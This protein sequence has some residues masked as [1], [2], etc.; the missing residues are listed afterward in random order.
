MNKIWI[1]TKVFIKNSGDTVTKGKKKTLPR[2]L[3]VLLVMGILMMSIGVP[4]GMFVAN[5]YEMLET[6]GQTGTILGFGI[7]IVSI[8]IFVFGI[9]YVLTT[10]YFSKD[11]EYLLPLPVKPYHI[12]TAKFVTVIIYEYFTEI[13]FL[14][15]VLV[16]YGIKS[17]GGF[18]YYFYSA[19][20]FLTLP[21][22]PLVVASAINMI[23]MRFTN[24][25]KHKDALRVAGGIFAMVFAIGINMTVQRNAASVDDPQ[26]MLSVIS[27]G[28]NS[29]VGL[30]SR[31]FP[32]ANFASWSLIESSSSK[33]IF[34]LVIFLGITAL[35]I[36]IFMIMAEMLYFRGV[37]GVSESYSKNRKLDSKT[38]EKNIVQSSAIKTYTLKELKLLFRTPSYFLNCVL[39]NFI[40]PVFLLLPAISQPEL[41]TALKNSRGFLN[42]T[43][44][45]GIVIAAGFGAGVFIA[46][47]TGISA[48]AISREGQNIF[49]GKYLPMRYSDQIMAKV[50]S[51]VI[52]NLV[53]IIVALGV[54]VAIVKL[55][56]YLIILV[57]IAAIS[58]IFLIGFTGIFIDLNFPKLNWDNEQKAV[59]QNFN[60]MI[61]MFLAMLLAAGIVFMTIYFKLTLIQAFVGIV[62]V[63]GVINII[64]FYILSTYG[65]KLYNK[66]EA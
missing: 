15:P 37:V 26:K 31:F 41:L 47:T 22:I 13:V 28:K 55:P 52:L 19:I 24:L 51:G 25:G 27:E 7:S 11:I 60:L 36:G 16:A 40:W 59:K 61:N 5:G 45:L 6:M 29:L 54:A 14:L 23:I 2:G 63:T 34:N 39:M 50:L 33:G 30:S 12:L 57:A 18:L 9:F 43:Y 10:F 3:S 38:L 56:V 42:N 46:G 35:F 66:I 64:L 62:S 20:I 21:I 32:S 44:A 17:S 1:L 8:A 48:T 4:F 65:E 49:V 53:G 58:G